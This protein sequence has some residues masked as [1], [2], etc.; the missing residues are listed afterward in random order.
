MTV[1]ARIERSAELG[2]RQLVDIEHHECVEAARG[3]VLKQI[4]V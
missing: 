1:P 3:C 4:R 2:A